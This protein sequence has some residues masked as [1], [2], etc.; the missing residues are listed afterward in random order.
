MRLHPHP[1]HTP[2]GVACEAGC[3]GRREAAVR[4]AGVTV[5]KAK[6]DPKFLIAAASC[7]IG[8]WSG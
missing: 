1:R 3:A 4:E 2:A 6:L 7:A 8:G 5:A